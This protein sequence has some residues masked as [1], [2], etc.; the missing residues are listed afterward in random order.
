MARKSLTRVAFRPEVPTACEGTHSFDPQQIINAMTFH[1]RDEGL[2]EKICETCVAA[3]LKRFNQSG[4]QVSLSK[5]RWMG[6]THPQRLE[7]L[8]ASSHTEVYCSEE[9]LAMFREA[10]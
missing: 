3:T 4:T 2:A 10:R 5:A 1:V 8:L 6:M 9:G 7:W